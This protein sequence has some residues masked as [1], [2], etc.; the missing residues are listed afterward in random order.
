MPKKLLIPVS[1]LYLVIIGFLIFAYF[2]PSSPLSKKSSTSKPNLV[3]QP[4]PTNDLVRIENAKGELIFT[5]GENCS[6]LLKLFQEQR[7]EALK[8]AVEQN[9][10]VKLGELKLEYS[11]TLDVNQDGKVTAY[12]GGKIM[13]NIKNEDW[14]SQ[15]FANVNKDNV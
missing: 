1:F 7:N 11:P 14:C 15:Q 6:K 12:D 3:S 5:V 2:S 9:K 4:M 10:E 13:E 8:M